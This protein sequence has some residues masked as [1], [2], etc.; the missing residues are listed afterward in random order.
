MADKERVREWFYQAV[1]LDGRE[2]ARFLRKIA[3]EDPGAQEEVRSL[4]GFANSNSF[5]FV[6]PDLLKAEAESD[7]ESLDRVG[8]YQLEH[9]LGRG[10][11]GR[12]YRARQL[13]PIARTVALKVIKPGMDTE[14]ALRRF[15]N[16]RRTLERLEHPGIARALDAG[17]DDRGRPYFV[18]EL[19]DGPTLSEYCRLHELDVRGRLKLFQQVC[20]GVAYA[21][22]RGL[23]HRDLKPGNVLVVNEGGEARAKIV[24][25]GLATL[26][27]SDDGA[28]Q[29]SFEFSQAGMKSPV[30]TLG[31]MSP[32]QVARRPSDERSDVYSLGVILYVL[33][34]GVPPH[35]G[36][37][38]RD[39]EP[40]ELARFLEDNPITPPTRRIE[41]S[42]GSSGLGRPSRELDWIC[43]RAMEGSPEQRYSSAEEL[44]DDVQRFLEGRVVQAV[45]PS[46]VYRVRKWV[47]RHGV[48]IGVVVTIA[49]TST[50]IAGAATVAFFRVRDAR[51]EAQAALAEVEVSADYLTGMLLSPDPFDL[52]PDTTIGA[53]LSRARETF[54]D[55]LAEAPRV[56]VRLRPVLAGA[57]ASLKQLDLARELLD[58]ALAEA[59]SV[60]GPSSKEAAD[61][62]L[63]LAR[64]EE[65]NGHHKEMR[66]EAS[67]ANAVYTELMHPDPLASLMAKALAARALATGTDIQL[68]SQELAAAVS[69]ATNRQLLDSEEGVLVRMWHA[70]ILRWNGE[71]DRGEQLLRELREVAAGLEDPDLWYLAPKVGRELAATLLDAGQPQ[72]AAREFDDVVSAYAEH[73]GLEHGATLGVR[74]DRAMAYYL[75]GQPERA[76]EDMAEV[77]AGYE[78]SIG[79]F[80]TRTIDLKV[81]YLS[82]L[83]GIG[84]VA[85]VL[86]EI[87]PLIVGMS[88]VRGPRAIQTAQ[89]IAIRG[90]SLIKSG[91][92]V[93]GLEELERALEIFQERQATG[94]PIYGQIVGDGAQALRELGD[95]ESAAAWVEQFRE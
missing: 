68:A 42:T 69:F 73:L 34:A 92:L 60:F 49:L 44:G 23:L 83:M 32:E 11:M 80:A 76:A 37:D 91:D 3:K 31:Y 8:P 19:V 62:H 65:R 10:G 48:A 13:E 61:V 39:R 4:L 86:E 71:A 46:R 55:D 12:V 16:E 24:D 38:L 87:E 28:S 6:G 59:E 63:A 75:S 27:E 25:F 36:S 5:D 82:I 78:A 51:D 45:P 26:L 79:P 22:G 53:M 1:E 66:D 30:G 89:A 7:S 94:M 15:R 70:G 14:S 56:R 95:E 85:R 54:D 35:K 33:L 77:I 43:L 17:V 21:H 29:S 41:S 72:E 67:R 50:A 9:L 90:K 18:M 47:R 58:E 57:L 81:N 20:N 93:G 84:D 64:L 40:K 2:R 52:G 74:S 88:K